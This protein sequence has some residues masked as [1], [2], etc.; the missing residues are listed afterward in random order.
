MFFLIK[1]KEPPPTCNSRGNK[2]RY[3]GVN[4]LLKQQVQEG[5]SG[6]GGWWA[7]SRVWGRLYLLTDLLSCGIPQHSITPC[8]CRE[9]FKTCY[10]VTV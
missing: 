7:Y 6:W 5:G 1:K 9:N 8:I 10:N 4:F 3:K 2:L